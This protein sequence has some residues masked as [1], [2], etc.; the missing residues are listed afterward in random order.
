MGFW[1]ELEGDLRRQRLSSS[2]A[3]H[4]ICPRLGAQ[5]LGHSSRSYATHVDSNIYPENNRTAD[6]FSPEPCIEKLLHV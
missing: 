1:A 5:A 2:E 6:C 4:R 3:N